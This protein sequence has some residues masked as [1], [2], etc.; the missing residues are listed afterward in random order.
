MTL[1]IK[2]RTE[3]ET[4]NDIMDEI[5]PKKNCDGNICQDEVRCVKDKF[6]IT[7]GTKILHG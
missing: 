6:G 7:E 5:K 1:K 3:E 4:N 2:K